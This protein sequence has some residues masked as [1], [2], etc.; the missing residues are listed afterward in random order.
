MK[1]NTFKDTKLI[2]SDISFAEENQ[3]AI[4]RLKQKITDEDHIQIQ[5]ILASTNKQ[6]CS[7][8]APKRPFDQDLELA[9][10]PIFR[11]SFSAFS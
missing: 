5:I 1:K 9:N 11:L 4:S 2:K 10:S 3:Y 8:S 6:T 7:V